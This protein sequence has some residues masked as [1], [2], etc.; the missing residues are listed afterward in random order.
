M[1]TEFTTAELQRRLKALDRYLAAAAD[2]ILDG[3]PSMAEQQRQ[4]EILR[5]K[6]SLLRQ[7][8]QVAD[9]DSW[10]Q[11]KTGL[12]ADLNALAENLERWM[13]T[14]DR[15]FRANWSREERRSSS[16]S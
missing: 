5:L 13:K 1:D 11:V 2:K 3:G 9:A 12:Q 6:S 10:D 8:L 16:R 15:D 4:I 14:I 7:R